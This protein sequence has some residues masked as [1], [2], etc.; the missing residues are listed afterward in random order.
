V[1]F[2]CNGT[3]VYRPNIV[4]SD[5]KEQGHIS[6]ELQSVGFSS[7]KFI[8]TCYATLKA[9]GLFITKSHR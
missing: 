7:P 5:E 3:R 1:N 9:N 8:A 6:E 2:L 4:E